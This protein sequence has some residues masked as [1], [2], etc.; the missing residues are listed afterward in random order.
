MNFKLKIKKKSNEY[1]HIIHF[2]A[3]LLM[4]VIEVAMFAYLWYNEYVPRLS[5]INQSFWGRGNYA[6]IGIYA[7]FMYFF[8]KNFG[9]YKVGYLTVS[10]VSLSKIIAIIVTNIFAYVQISIVSKK[11]YLSLLPLVELTGVQLVFA[12]VWIFFIRY[13]YLRLYPAKNMLLIYGDHVPKS[14]IKKVNARDDRYKILEIAD[15][16]IGFNKL[17][18]HILRHEI[19]L[20]CDLPSQIRNQLL[21]FCYNEEKR[22]YIIPTI[23]D[24]IISGA[25]N[26]DLFD[27]PLYRLDS[28]GINLE[29][30]IVKRIEDI[31]ISLLLT[32]ISAPFMLIFAL[33]IKLTDGGPIFYTQERL[34]RDGISFSI[35]KLRSMCV[36]A[37]KEGSRLACKGDKRIT[38]IGRFL[39]ATHL[40]ELPQIYNILKGDMSV[41]GPRPERAEIVAEYEEFVPEFKFRLKTKAGLT[42]YAQVY[43]KY[44]TTPYD[45]LKLDLTYIENYSLWLDIK[46]ILLT[47][48]IMFQ[49]EN[50]EGI[51][52]EQKTAVTRDKDVD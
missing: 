11:V 22:I 16:N 9:G 17:S 42:G 21:K 31:L 48:K 36:D 35:I 8:T 19:I 33:C 44:N 12:I 18:Q 52:E 43:G 27:T 40:D 39:R 1:K 15:V 26:V 47:F 51:E 49:K 6:V 45:K 34:S 50:T 23:S 28:Q 10:D 25:G 41:V 20:F 46:I 30:R 2:I 29:Q 38:P 37:E 7:L 13:I 5:S 24:V 3:T 14:L 4:L 32:I